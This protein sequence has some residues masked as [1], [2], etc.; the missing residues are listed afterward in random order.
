MS[1]QR[2]IRAGRRNVGALKLSNLRE[3][4]RFEDV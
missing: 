4:D 2:E 1:H 3:P